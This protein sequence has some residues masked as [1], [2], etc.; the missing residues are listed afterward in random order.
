MTGTM[1][2]ANVCVAMDMSMLNRL[3]KKLASS[4]MRNSKVA[5]VTVSTSFQCNALDAAAL[6]RWN[7][8]LTFLLVGCPGN[9]ETPLS[10]GGGKKREAYPIEAM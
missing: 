9:G 4:V 3:S 6:T 5:S 7:H 8:P 10:A 2:V 1:V